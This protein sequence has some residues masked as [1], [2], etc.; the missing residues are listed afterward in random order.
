MES[1]ILIVDD[2]RNNL[3]LLRATLKDDGYKLFFAKNG[4]TALNQVAKHNPDLIL[5]DIMMPDMDGYE[6]CQ[7][8]K[9]DDNT[10]DIPIIFVTAKS[11]EADET[12]G[13]AMGVVDYITKPI[14]QAIVRARVKTQLKILAQRQLLESQN[15]SLE[16]LQREQEGFFNMAVHDLRN[17][18]TVI[19]GNVPF[20]FMDRLPLDK[21][22]KRLEAIKNHA[23]KMRN[24]T[25]EILR[26]QKLKQGKM[27]FNMEKI[28]VPACIRQTVT[29][30]QGAASLFEVNLVAEG[31]SPANIMGDVSFLD[32]VLANLISNALKYS[33]KGDTVTIGMQTVNETRIRITVAD[34]GPGIP[35]ELQ[36]RIFE[37]FAQ[38]KDQ[39][40][41]GTGLGMT[42]CKLAT[43]GMGGQ[44]GFDT[45]SQGTTFWV[46]FPK[47]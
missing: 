45:S 6:V 29:D 25:E 38:A 20:I 4:Q 40:K 28:D 7:R 13:L 3:D 15:T 27:P 46:E 42:I 11:E 30:N 10:K 8:L 32:R 34:N 26:L 24:L 16:Q 44:I 35:K 14:S 5:L 22:K 17:P 33:P 43:E 12:K 23:E 21:R 2:E 1:K 47:I 31:M 9:A 39:R 19:I 41:E 36:L 18:L 37:A